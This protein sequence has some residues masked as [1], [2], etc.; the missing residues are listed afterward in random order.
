METTKVRRA[1]VIKRTC[2]NTIFASCVEPECYIDRDWLKELKT[3][4]KAGCHIDILECK[5]F[6]FE[7]CVCPKP[8]T[9]LAL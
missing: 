6:T 4:V 8:Q 3:Y 5:T 9:E 7:S 2:C 1:Q